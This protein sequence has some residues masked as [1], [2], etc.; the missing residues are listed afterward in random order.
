MAYAKAKFP[1]GSDY[2][3]PKL[4]KVYLVSIHGAGEG[5]REIKIDDDGAWPSWS[6]SGALHYNQA[7]GTHTRLM[8]VEH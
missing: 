8:R 5:R 4:W 1:G 2:H 7:D 6:Q 3:D